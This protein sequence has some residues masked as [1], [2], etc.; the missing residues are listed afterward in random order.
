MR[1]TTVH[2]KYIGPVVQ[3]PYLLADDWHTQPSL[4]GI[5]I[6][7]TIYCIVTF[8]TSFSLF[9]Y[10]KYKRG[11]QTWTNTLAFWFNFSNA[12][13]FSVLINAGWTSNV[14]VIAAAHNAL[15]LIIVLTLYKKFFVDFF[16]SAFAYKVI[17]DIAYVVGVLSVLPHLLIID[18]ELGAKIKAFGGI[19]DFILFAVSLV[20]VTKYLIDIFRKFVRKNPDI[21]PAPR[22]HVA[23]L[24]TTLSHTTTVMIT[25][26]ACFYTR[27]QFVMIIVGT[28]I[29][30]M[31]GV[32]YFVF[33]ILDK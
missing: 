23:L 22:R 1:N 16:H 19:S 28:L 7:M 20:G 9:F 10:H 2:N 32:V 31:A 33:Q 24:I 17:M 8:L 29:M 18:F 3:M 4:K 11:K 21:H 25:F 14:F 30:N 12:F 26:A 6:F 13:I 15:E 27:L 5:R